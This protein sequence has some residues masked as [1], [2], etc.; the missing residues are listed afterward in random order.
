MAVIANTHAKRGID[1]QYSRVIIPDVRGTLICL[2]F[3]QP[4]L[5][6]DVT[7]LIILMV[8]TVSMRRTTER[9][10]WKSGY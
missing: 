9:I 2:A 8:A 1:D 3:S 10:L 7:G 6:W 5:F 4:P